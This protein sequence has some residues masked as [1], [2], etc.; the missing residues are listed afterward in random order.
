MKNKKNLV[1]IGLFILIAAII[2]LISFLLFKTNDNKDNK[3]NKKNNDVSEQKSVTSKDVIMTYELALEKANRIYS[4]DTNEVT[5]TEESNYF[6][7]NV[8]DKDTN[9]EVK[10][11]MYKVG[12]L[13]ERIYDRTVTNKGPVA[14]GN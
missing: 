9:E 4:S 5:I 6:L 1:I 10:Y 13:V 14:S 3:S 11:R 7:I 12:G 2:V 8:K